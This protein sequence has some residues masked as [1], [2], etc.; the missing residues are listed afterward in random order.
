M[1][2]LYITRGGVSG[3]VGTGEIFALGA[4]MAWW[5]ARTNSLRPA[6]AVHLVNNAV[7]FTLAL[8]L[9]GLP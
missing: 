6:Y 7:A 2:G 4:L 3:W 9:P 1:H 5:A 8:L